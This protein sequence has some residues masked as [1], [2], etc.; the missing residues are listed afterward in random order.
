M[1]YSFSGILLLTIGVLLLLD[2]LDVLSFGETIGKFWP[3][4]LIIWG[5][6]FL[7]RRKRTENPEQIF[8]S[9][10]IQQTRSDDLIHES[11]VFG[12]IFISI[13]SPTFKGGS[14]STVFGDSDI[15][16]SKCTFAEGDHVLRVHGVFGD[17]RIIL[18]NDAPVAV[19]ANST[20]GK[21]VIF[22][23]RKDGISSSTETATPTYA[24]S[25]ARL[26]IIVSKVFGDVV[27]S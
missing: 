24:A 6:S 21:L 26:K 9:H 4:L 13:S 11:N 5:F 18:G 27:I 22:N 15:D 19:S 17:S 1:R 14:I 10:D 23:Q 16:L 7:Q 12:D 2:N 25:T 8:A 3:I 20:F